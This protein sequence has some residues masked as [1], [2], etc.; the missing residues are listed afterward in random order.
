[1][2]SLLWRSHETSAGVPLSLANQV[3]AAFGAHLRRMDSASGNIQAVPG[4]VAFSLTVRCN[5][6]LTTK[7]NVRGRRRM[8][9]VRVEH[10]RPVF[11]NVGVRKA[12]GAQPSARRWRS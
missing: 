7:H 11:P 3:A 5:C 10:S 1:M 8:R 12:L 4:F 2:R 9:V 6:H